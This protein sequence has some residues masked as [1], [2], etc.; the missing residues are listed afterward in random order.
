MKKIIAA[1]ALA[2]S[3]GTAVSL[4]LP[5]EGASAGRHSIATV[6]KYEDSRN[7]VWDAKHRGNG[8]GRSFINRNGK[9]IFISHRAAH[10]LT[11]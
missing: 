10:A 8:K 3:T 9:V 4:A 11:H 5:T 7:C 2:L 1:L 6:C